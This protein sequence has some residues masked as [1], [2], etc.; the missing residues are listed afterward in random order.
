MNV[1]Y[2]FATL[3]F[4]SIYLVSSAQTHGHCGTDALWEQTLGE[5]PEARRQFALQEA[6][7]RNW[8]R[9][10]VSS[11]GA[12]TT[13]TIPVV[14]HLIQYSAFESIS[15]ARVQSQIDVL[16][17]DF[18]L[19]AA[20][21]SAIP[22][23]FRPLAANTEIQFC[24]ATIDP[25]GC[26]TDGIVRV[27][28]PDLADHD[29]GQSGQMKALSYWP[30]DRYLNMWVPAT[31]D[32]GILGY[33][34][35]PFNLQT[36]P[37][38]D[39]VVINARFFGRGNGIA[40]SSYALGRTGTHEVGH[41][42]GLFHTFQ[43]GCSGMNASN[44]DTG[45]DRVCDTPPTANSNFG[46]PGTQNTCNESPQDLNDMTVNFMDYGDDAC[47]LMYSF[48][49]KDRMDFFLN[50][51]RSV[52]WSPANLTA[53]GCDGTP[54]P[55]CQ[56]IARIGAEKTV[57][58]AGDSIV[59]TD[60]STG[61]P[62][63]LSWDFPSAN[64]GTATQSTVT[65][66]FPQTGTYQVG[67]TATNS[68]GSASDSLA[69]LVV[70][71]MMPP[72][73]EGFEAA[74]LP[75]G[76]SVFDEDQAGTWELAATGSAG[77][78][79]IVVRNYILREEGTQDDLTS[80]PFDLSWAT[81]ARLTFDRAYKRRDAFSPDSLKVLISTDCGANWELLWIRGGFGLASTPGLAIPAEFVPTAAQW[82]TDTIDLSAYIGQSSCQLR[83][84][85]IGANGQSLYLDQINLDATI[86]GR[87]DPTGTA[88]DLRI[89]PN[90][91]VQAP[92]I[93]FELARA[94]QVQW[95]VQDLRGKVRW[96]SG[97]TKLAQ[98]RHMWRFTAV[99]WENLSP[100][101]YLIS[102]TGQTGRVS[103]KLIKR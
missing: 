101:M 44:C 16:N 33:A 29:T 49:Q 37:A 64:P 70:D 24:L 55:G 66:A 65:V 87:G 46:C 15:D 41:W 80:L 19:M 30:A 28:A 25:N 73:S 74:S 68:I 21:T 54:A 82:V 93:R 39:G 103:K 99:E 50:G 97:S 53:T 90:P 57:V 9:T 52:I 48:G 94:D 51:V 100:G 45:G 4:C 91:A 1:R 61:P 78:Q 34:T 8:V 5:S 84:E 12:R 59:F 76:W 40:P 7:Y 31:I 56:P 43:G 95:Q 83:F 38:E 77:Q 75:L 13:I 6:Q 22:A 47:L 17:E 10:N 62:T 63:S 23:E 79:S 69:I 58:C 71:P 92:E 35:F 72:V 3:L 96:Q 11:S 2:F 67:L 85:C 60:L 14:A 26:P 27:V 32:G 36:N 89:V 18:G 20:D 102:L 88:A 98:G 81:D 42:L 86:V